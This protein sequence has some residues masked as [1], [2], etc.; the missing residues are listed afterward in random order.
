MKYAFVT[1]PYPVIISAEVHCS[2]P[3]QDTMASIMHE[4]FG[5]SLI[6]APVNGRPKI[7]V[8][9][10]PE[11]LKGRVLLKVCSVYILSSPSFILIRV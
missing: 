5:E 2:V 6:S 10:S 9:P 8:L 4:V 11:D 3:Q 1:S 7:E